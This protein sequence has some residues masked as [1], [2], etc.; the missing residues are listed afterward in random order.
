MI[1]QRIAN[2]FRN[3]WQAAKLE[4]AER[5]KAEASADLAAAEEEL[6]AALREYSAEVERSKRL[7]VEL[8]Q[9]LDRL[10]EIFADAGVDIVLLGSVKSDVWERLQAQ[11]VMR[12]RYP[13]LR[14]RE[15]DAEV[16]PAESGGWP[17]CQ[18][19]FPRLTGT[20]R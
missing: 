13:N 12:A 11:N 1:A 14:C 2:R 3:A 5:L 18:D 17:Y 19:H 8:K 9:N 6:R 10:F 16:D 4:T 7:D 15:C 20:T